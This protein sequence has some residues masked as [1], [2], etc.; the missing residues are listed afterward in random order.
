MN[1]KKATSVDMKVERKYSSFYVIKI[2]NNSIGHEWWGKKNKIS[3]GLKA[4]AETK[5]KMEK[6][7]QPRDNMEN[8]MKKVTKPKE[9]R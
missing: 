9:W 6:S 5:L 3:V 8:P 2:F 4:K 7:S 1:H